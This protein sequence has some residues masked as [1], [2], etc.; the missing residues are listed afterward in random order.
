MS[1]P[2]NA[3][4]SKLSPELLLS[5]FA[6]VAVRRKVVFPVVLVR[7][8]KSIV[9]SVKAVAGLAMVRMVVKPEPLS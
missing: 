2:L 3:M 4:L 1:Q 5:L 9:W 6:P 7:P 8:V